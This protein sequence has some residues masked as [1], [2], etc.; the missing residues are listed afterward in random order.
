MLVTPQIGKYAGP[1]VQIHPIGPPFRARLRF[2][3]PDSKK[4]LDEHLTSMLTQ[5]VI[6]PSHSPWGAPVHFVSK[7]DGSKRLVIDYRELNTRIVRDTYPLPLTQQI[8]SDVA[9]HR[10]MIL[11]DMSWGFWNLPLEES[12]KYLT[13]F[14]TPSGLFESNVLPFGL[15][16]APSEFQRMSDAIFAHLFA[17]GL[18]VYIDDISLFSNDF[19]H[20]LD[21][22]ADALEAACRHGIFLKIKKCI[23]LPLEAPLLGHLV[24]VGG[25]R[26][27]PSRVDVLRKIGPPHDLRTLRSFLGTVNFFHN[28]V[29]RL[30]T[31]TA[32]FRPLLKKNVPFKWIAAMQQS[33]ENVLKALANAVP[34]MPPLERAPF[35]IFTDASSVGVGAVVLQRYPDG[36]RYPISFTSRAFNDCE[37][38][39][40]TREQ[41]AYAIKYALESNI[42]LIRGSEITIYTDN[43]SLTWMKDAP[44][45]KVQRWIWYIQQFSPKIVH[46]DGSLNPVAD[47]LSRCTPDDP[48]ADSP[49]ELLSVPPHPPVFSLASILPSP[50]DSSSA[51]YLL[52]LPSPSELRAAYASA[53]S[54]EIRLTYLSTSGFRF[55]IRSNK[56]YIPPPFRE[57]LLFLVHAGPFAMHRELMQCTGSCGNKSGGLV[58]RV[59]LKLSP[60]DALSVL[61]LVTQLSRLLQLF[62]AVLLLS[63]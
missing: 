10:Y 9:C 51:Q 60:V 6:R 49:I 16:N 21:L 43:S 55:A 50:S 34:V 11:L 62:F 54:N 31:V 35:E 27:V 1:S 39:W 58:F 41:E 4:L 37:R 44:Q 28:H 63:T 25:I 24:S 61:V 18:R 13:A 14:I 30:S 17:R 29:P 26:P 38:R 33:Y 46:V 8:L 42:D 3:S 2:C 48:S 56:L 20:L 53:P 5:G 36:V 52:R 59:M 15:A 19:R 12:S 22:L 47:W 32:P 40:D 45:A 7:R 57:S 23:I